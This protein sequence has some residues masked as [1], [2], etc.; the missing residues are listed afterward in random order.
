MYK[1]IAFTNTHRWGFWNRAHPDGVGINNINKFLVHNVINS[2]ILKLIKM[3]LKTYQ[4]PQ[5]QQ[6]YTILPKWP[7]LEFDIDEPEGKALLGS[8][9]GMAAGYFRRS[10][11]PRP[12]TSELTFLLQ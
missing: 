5:G 9:N 3:A 1:L 4:V 7:G 12:A 2:D 10:D 11:Q 8:P 6:R